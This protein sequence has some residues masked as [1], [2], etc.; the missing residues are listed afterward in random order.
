M[1]KLSA[2]LMA[3]ILSGSPAVLAGPDRPDV[4]GPSDS[5][6]STVEPHFPV[7]LGI[8]AI[9]LTPELRSHFGAPTDRGV[10]V[11]KVEQ[12]SMAWVA[13]LRVGD[14]LTSVRGENIDDAM[15]VRAAL[16]SAKRGDK[17]KLELIRDKKVMTLESTVAPRA[18]RAGG[19][20][21][22]LFPWLKQL[23]QISSAPKHGTAT[24]T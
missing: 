9:S 23:K 1:R 22:G 19:G 2:C 10:L 8:L 16:M 7:R 17:V 11:G 4:A 20:V 14:V 6:S 21:E 13:G 24:D 15:D 5:S 12:G 3:A 18:A